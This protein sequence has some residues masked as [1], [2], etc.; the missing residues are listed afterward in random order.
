MGCSKSISKREA[1]NITIVP[2]ETKKALNS[3]LTLHLKQLVKGEEENS[4]GKEI[5][6]I[7]AE[8]NENERNNSKV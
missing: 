1:Y 7:W 6:K 8:I 3:K 5:I 4:R 2:Q